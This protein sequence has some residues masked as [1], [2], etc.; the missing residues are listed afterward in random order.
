MKQGLGGFILV[1][2]LFLLMQILLFNHLHI[3]HTAFC[4]LFASILI[5]I[6]P[7]NGRITNLLIAFAIGII[8][9]VFNNSLGVHSFCCLT[10]MFARNNIYKI[11]SGKNEDEITDTELGISGIGL[12]A[13]SILTASIC[14]LYSLLY[15][16]VLAP[17]WIFFWNNIAQGFAS[18]VF[19]AIM[20]IL[21]NVIFFYKKKVV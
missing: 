9:D 10:L 11:L 5:T 20:I 7:K 18:G 6:S 13:F 8:I 2:A 17:K 15:F 3:G 1:S 21:V 16:F 12:Y 19:T 14:L 4:F